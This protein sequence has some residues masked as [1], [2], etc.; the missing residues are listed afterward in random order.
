ME[1]VNSLHSELVH[2]EKELAEVNS[3]L[4]D[5][6]GALLNSGRTEEGRRNLENDSQLAEN[7]PSLKHRAHNQLNNTHTLLRRLQE[8]Q[9]H[10]VVPPS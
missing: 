2:L 3:Q 7:K 8:K 4:Q 10:L 5:V 6:E 1:A 9:T